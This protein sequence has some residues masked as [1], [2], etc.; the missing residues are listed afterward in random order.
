MVM[1]RTA[2]VLFLLWTMSN[3]PVKGQVVQDSAGARL[4]FE[5]LNQVRENPPQFANTIHPALKKIP[6]KNKLHWN[7][8]LAR[9]AMEKA[10]DMATRK[11]F[12]HVSPE[13]QGMNFVLEKAGFKLI[14]AATSKKN[15]NFVESIHMTT[16][17]GWRQ[18]FIT[19]PEEAIKNLI[20]DKGVEGLGH[21]K[22]LLGIGPENENQKEAGIG[23]VTIKTRKGTKTYMCVLIVEESYRRRD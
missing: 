21:R 23:L 4:A 18:G 6:A 7:D 10:L 17:P 12:D 8:T 15:L 9:L 13:R 2:P 14:P 19:P 22:H 5:F 20:I 3:L 11:Y 1:M 16:E